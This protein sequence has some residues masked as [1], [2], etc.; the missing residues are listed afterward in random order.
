MNSFRAVYEKSTEVIGQKA[1]YKTG[2]TGHI[3]G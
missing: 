1:K 3:K 2:P